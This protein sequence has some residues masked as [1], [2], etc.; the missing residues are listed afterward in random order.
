MKLLDSIDRNPWAMGIRWMLVLPCAIIGFYTALL[1]S[2]GVHKVLNGWCP[3]G[4]VISGVCMV[5]WVR[6]L[7]MILGASIAP[8]LVII[9]GTLVAPGLRPLVAW[10]LYLGGLCIALT[11]TH[12]YML[13][14][15]ILA[16]VT[17]AATAAILHGKYRVR[18]KTGA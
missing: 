14:F 5:L 9:F 13:P 2:I 4:Q 6:L 10:V 17:G 7:P 8:V 15:G 16:G 1:L 3:G 11:F 12:G 18:D